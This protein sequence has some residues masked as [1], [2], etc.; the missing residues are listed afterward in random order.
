M[1]MRW[2]TA[3]ATAAV[4]AWLAGGCAGGGGKLKDFSAEQVTKD[5]DGQVESTAKLFVSPQRIRIEQPGR[6]GEAG[7]IIIVRR[8]QKLM[9]ILMP[10]NKAYMETPLNEAELQKTIKSLPVDAKEQVLGTET[11]N[12][13]RC[14]KKRVE[15]SMRGLFG[16][17]RSE[18]TVWVSDQL[19]MPLRTQQQNGG[20]TE[21]ANIRPGR[22]PAS[23]F[24]VPAGY[25]KMANPMEAMG[26]AFEQAGREMDRSASPKP[27]KKR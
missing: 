20:V 8:D 10:A 9:R 24:E 27:A 2:M 25:E 19:E 4:L 13:F 22:Q 12:G 17:I 26:R 16:D 18:A 1:Q 6:G 15:T 5:S 3:T 7:M 21:L 11:V 14:T 23:L